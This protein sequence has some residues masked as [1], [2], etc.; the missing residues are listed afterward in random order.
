[1]TTFLVTASRIPQHESVTRPYCSSWCANRCGGYNWRKDD[2]YEF[3]EWCA[4][5]GRF[6][7]A[8]A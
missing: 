2:R 8:S 4:N 3:D 1:M 6:I 5:C 7:K